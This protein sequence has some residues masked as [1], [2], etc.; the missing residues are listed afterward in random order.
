MCKIDWSLIIQALIAAGT[1]LVA[2]I[3]IW[4]DWIRKIFTPPRLKIIP[5]DLI[6][7]KYNNETYF[8]LK[9]KNN[10][11]WSTV[12]NCKVLLAEVHRLN[13]DGNFIEKK[14]NAP[15]SFIWTSSQQEGQNISHERVFDFGILFSQ[16]YFRP[17]INPMPNNFGDF[18]LVKKN[19]TVPYFLRIT[20]EGYFGKKLQIF[21]VKWKSQTE[22]NKQDNAIVIK[23]IS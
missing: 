1:L 9:V 23:E 11:T 3:A 15:H 21:E 6:G 8:R 16:G 10:R 4:N 20:G 14:L 17:A 5:Q 22:N 13:E 7:E 2:I 12:H 18:G 19:D